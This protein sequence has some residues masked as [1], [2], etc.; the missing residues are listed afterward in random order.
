MWIV[1]CFLGLWIYATYKHIQ[2]RARQDDEYCKQIKQ[3]DTANHAAFKRIDERNNK[4]NRN[5]E[6]DNGRD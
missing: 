5:S 2:K 4:Q 1:L 6:S 3:R